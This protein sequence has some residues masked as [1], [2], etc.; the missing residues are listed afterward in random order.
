MLSWRHS[1]DHDRAGRAN[2]HVEAI[3]NIQ[4]QSSRT[5]WDRAASRSIHGRG[6]RTPAPAPLFPHHFLSLIVAQPRQTNAF[7]PDGSYSWTCGAF[8]SQTSPFWEDYSDDKSFNLDVR[9]DV[10][11]Q[12]VQTLPLDAPINGSNHELATANP[13]Q[14]SSLLTHKP[15]QTFL[16]CAWFPHRV[17]ESCPLLEVWRFG[18]GVVFS[19]PCSR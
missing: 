6:G 12:A 17:R 1:V 3:K 11:S 10:R 8:T 7:P 15:H 14:P 19:A 4:R 9:R 2:P 13:N 16:P 5:R 18:R